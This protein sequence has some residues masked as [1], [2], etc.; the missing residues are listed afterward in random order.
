MS[1]ISIADPMNVLRAAQQRGAR[2]ASSTRAA[3]N[4]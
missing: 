1:F 3:S 2:S 4:R